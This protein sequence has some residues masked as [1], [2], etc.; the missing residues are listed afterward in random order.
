[1][2]LDDEHLYTD[3]FTKLEELKTL[4]PSPDI[5]ELSD[6]V[7]TDAASFQRLKTE[8]LQIV[9]HLYATHKKFQEVIQKIDSLKSILQTL[10]TSGKYIDELSAIIEQF[11]KEE[12]VDDIKHD[13]Q[14]TTKR[15]Q[16]LRRV[17]NV[18]DIGEQYMCFTCL[19]RRVD[20]FLY[21]CGHVMCTICSVSIRD[22]CPFCRCANITK[23]KMFLG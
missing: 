12:C 9:D 10:S 2:E 23:C 15:F 6:D 7:Q 3:L 16:M 17:L 19:Q 14:E 11:Q 4:S 5:E 13:I 1:M 22:M 21:P 20:T 8:Y 18:S